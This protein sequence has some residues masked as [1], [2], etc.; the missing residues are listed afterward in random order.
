MVV[1]IIFGIMTA[2]A[3]PAFNNMIMNAKL[4]GQMDELST[5]LNYARSTAL[6]QNSPVQVCP[7]G[8]AGSTTCG[9]NWATGWIVVTAPTAA[10]ITAGATVT[11]LQSHTSPTTIT[12]TAASA[13]PPL[14]TALGSVVFDTHGLAT[15]SAYFAF[16]DNRTNPEKYAKTAIV[17]ATG[18]V[19]TAPAGVAAWNGGA[20]TCTP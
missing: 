1:L 6:S 16:C 7:I 3:L 18:F 17:N 10:A 12:L 9:T 8:T 4:S 20:A 13:A 19:Q 2:M 5:A 15:T 11:L 14:T